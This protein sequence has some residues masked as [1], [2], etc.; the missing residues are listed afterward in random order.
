MS[1][2]TIKVSTIVIMQR[3][4]EGKRKIVSFNKKEEEEE[5]E[6]EERNLKNI[7]YIYK[8]RRK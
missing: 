8:E 3:K 7:I 2:H 4:I 6:K 1:M 5:E